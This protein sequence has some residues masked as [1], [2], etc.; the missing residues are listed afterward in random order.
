MSIKMLQTGSKEWSVGLDEVM[1]QI[2]ESPHEGLPIGVTPN[3]VVFGRKRKMQT[4]DPPSK[5]GI[6]MA[7]SEDA[8][9][10]ICSSDTS[11][12]PDEPDIGAVELA[13]EYNIK[14]ADEA[15][16][17]KDDNESG[18]Q[19]S[20]D[21]HS[22]FHLPSHSFLHSL[23]L[24]PHSPLSPKGKEKAVE[25]TLSDQEAENDPEAAAAEEE[26][27]EESGRESESREDSSE[28]ENQEDKEDDSDCEKDIH[29][30]ARE[31]ANDTI[32][33]LDA[34]ILKH[35]ARQREKMQKKYNASHR[36]HIFKEGDFATLAIP[37]EIRAPT[38]N[39][40]LE[41]KIVEVSRQNRYRV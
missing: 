22:S 41:V 35:Q 31:P 2:N 5:R 1:K 9:N 11:P 19:R 26:E 25:M 21:P 39:L 14:E 13:L 24:S 10:R 12:D 3:V 28:D 6:I 23:F 40:R 36:V 8:I 38:D 20:A 4:R 17:D 30:N 18:P 16:D 33:T 34:Q 27:A 15:E 32:R 29:P 7:V 37:K